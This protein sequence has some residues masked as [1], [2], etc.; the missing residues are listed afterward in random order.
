MILFFRG[1]AATGK[2]LVAN[3]IAEKHSFKVMSKDSVFDELL[4]NG[5]DWDVAT[6]MAY[7]E[8]A[9]KIQQ[10][11]DAEQTLI[12]DIG[13][14]H[15]PYFNTFLSKLTLKPEQVRYF[16][17]DCSDEAIWQQRIETRIQSTSAPNQAFK[18]AQEAT[19]HYKRY[20]ISL[21][22]NEKRIDSSQTMEKM[23][24]DITWM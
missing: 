13:L 12:V 10:N 3:A 2:S 5:Y 22:E 4:E 20:E 16:L 1:K 8:L 18:T 14:A 17:F 24:E 11:H 21:I 7:D 23:M 19:E 9:L 15:T 6:E